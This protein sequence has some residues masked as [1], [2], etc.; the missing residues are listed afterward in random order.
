VRLEVFVAFTVNVL[1]FGT[2][3]SQFPPDVVLIGDMKTELMPTPLVA[4]TVT[5]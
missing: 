1:P 3:D 2:A 4:V 5:I